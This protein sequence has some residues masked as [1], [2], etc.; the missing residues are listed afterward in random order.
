MKKRII[1]TFMLT[2]IVLSVSAQK[3]EW[4]D[5]G[6]NAVNRAEM[7]TNYFAYESLLRRM[8]GG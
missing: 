6:I 8:R 3:N 2:T 4:Q 7:H 1:S 5:P